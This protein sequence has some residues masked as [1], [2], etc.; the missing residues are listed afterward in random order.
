MADSR[1]DIKGL[2]KLRLK[3]A[4]MKDPK[5]VTHGIK[6]AALHLQKE[7]KVYPPKPAHSTYR[8][9]LNLGKRWA[10]NVRRLGATVSNNTS[11]GPFVQGDEQTWFHAETGWKTT[12]EIAE[13]ETEEVVK[14]IKRAVDRVLNQ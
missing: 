4:F 2:D 6:D 8:R 11:Y 9:T 7:A 5:G 1:I 14:I 13:D 12:G 10:V 3:L